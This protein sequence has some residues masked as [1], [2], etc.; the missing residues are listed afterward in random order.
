MHEYLLSLLIFFPLLGALIVLALPSESLYGRSIALCIALIQ[1][2]I[3]I[4]IL[5]NYDTSLAGLQLVER[6]QWISLT[7][8]TWG[9]L[10]ADYFVALDGLSLPLIGLSVFIFIVA[11]V[12]SWKVEKSRKG[13]FTLL[14]VLNAAVMGTFCA[15]DFLL[16]YL[17][18]EFMLLP[19]FFLIGIWGGARREYASIKFF[20]YTLLGSILIIIVMIALLLSTKSSTDPNMLVHSF[21]ISEMTN[22]ANILSQSILDP[23]RGLELFGISVRMWAFIFLFI[24]FGIKLPMVPFHT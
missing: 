10:R 13:Y 20:L 8:G 6:A 7:M 14:L 19:M 17:F 18:F 2:L 24:G 16:F 3:F 9:E 1:V 12:S 23:Q 15:Q 4:F 5:A 11:S 21:S 22:P